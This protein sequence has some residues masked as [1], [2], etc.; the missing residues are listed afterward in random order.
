[1]RGRLVCAEQETK[2]HIEQLATSA[3]ANEIFT[4]KALGVDKGDED[5]DQ[6]EEV[7]TARVDADA[8]AADFYDE[9]EAAPDD[10]AVASEG[11]K[12]ELRAL[13]LKNLSAE[14]AARSEDDYD[15]SDN[16]TTGS[17]R[18]V[19]PLA[20]SALPGPSAQPDVAKAGAAA[21]LSA[22]LS[23]N[24][25]TA[26]D[27]ELEQ[28]VRQ[29]LE[30]DVELQVKVKSNAILCFVDMFNLG[31]RSCVRP[32]RP[33]RRRLN[34]TVS[35]EPVAY[36][37]DDIAVWC[38]AVRQTAAALRAQREAQ[39]AAQSDARPDDDDESG[40]DSDSAS[41]PESEVNPVAAPSAKRPLKRVLSG[42]GHPLVE[43]EPS[44][45]TVVDSV[46]A[47][48]ESI[49]FSAIHQVAWDEAIRWDDD[50]SEAS[51]GNESENE[52]AAP[53]GRLESQYCSTVQAPGTPS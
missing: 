50:E 42:S 18:P 15:D 4:T 43:P 14:P 51:S 6:S 34:A 40:S 44:G 35:N 46:G 9:A 13:A 2:Q 23:I 32:M 41:A 24:F 30:A 1:M 47:P 20:T 29:E 33:K 49:D 7:A 38:P 53:M 39:R 22:Q 21:Q 45:R 26:I 5:Y 3:K 36:Q 25:P 52:T 28:A 11:R 12:Q 17:S 19:R 31:S 37:G 8:S 48:V 10:L 16:E 27:A